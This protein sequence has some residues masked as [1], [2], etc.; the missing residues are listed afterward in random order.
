MPANAEGM[1]SSVDPDQTAPGALIGIN[2]SVS[3][4]FLKEGQASDQGWGV[5][6]TISKPYTLENR[7][8]SGIQD[9]L[10]ICAWWGCPTCMWDQAV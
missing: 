2:N 1:V 9:P 6:F 8:G 4:H 7:G 3:G 5:K 10:C